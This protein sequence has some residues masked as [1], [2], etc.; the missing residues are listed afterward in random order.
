MDFASEAQLLGDE[1]FYLAAS[2]PPRITHTSGITRASLFRVVFMPG[3]SKMLHGQ[4][5]R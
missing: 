2:K 1:R 5:G 3:A 4:L